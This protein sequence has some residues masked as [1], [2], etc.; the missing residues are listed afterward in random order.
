MNIYWI[1]LPCDLLSSLASFQCSL[2]YHLHLSSD[3][4]LSK[5]ESTFPSKSQ[6]ECP[7]VCPVLFRFQHTLRYCIRLCH[8]HAQ[9]TQNMGPILFAHNENIAHIMPRVT[10]RAVTSCVHH[11]VHAC[12]QASCP[13]YMW[14]A[15]I[16][17]WTCRLRKP[18]DIYQ[19]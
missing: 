17:L 11:T 10:A 1:S 6:S 16:Y 19:K 12:Q 15:R 13:N 4:G 5:C 2:L 18:N 14:H 3:M 7:S 9:H 8:H